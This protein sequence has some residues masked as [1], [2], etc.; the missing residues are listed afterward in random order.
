[1]GGPTS[2]ETRTALPGGGDAE[3]KRTPHALRRGTTGMCMCVCSLSPPLSR[4]EGRRGCIYVRARSHSLSRDE[5]RRGC[6]ARDRAAREAASLRASTRGRP[7]CLGRASPPRAL[8]RLG[9]QARGGILCG[10][11]FGGALCS[12]HLVCPELVVHAGEDA[13]EGSHED[14]PH[15]LRESGSGG[16]VERREDRSH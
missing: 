13:H 6:R 11:C 8:T 9:T 15:H 7:L 10:P 4:G 3:R 16:R 2:S 12:S 14:K 1:M 5:G